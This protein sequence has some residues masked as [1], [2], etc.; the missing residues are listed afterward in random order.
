MRD[1]KVLP[2][3]WHEL[4]ME[5][6][7]E[8][9]RRSFVRLPV[10]WINARLEERDVPIRVTCMPNRTVLRISV[11]RDGT[12]AKR[13]LDRLGKG[14]AAGRIVFGLLPREVV[15]DLSCRYLDHGPDG[16]FFLAVQ[17]FSPRFLGRLASWAL[18]GFAWDV[19][20]KRLTLFLPRLPW[21]GSALGGAAA[22]IVYGAVS[23]VDHAPDALHLAVTAGGG[24]TAF[25]DAYAR[26]VAEPPRF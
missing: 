15:F 3:P 8:L 7:T 13:L 11:S 9:L 2:S 6:D 1:M 10:R 14:K 20:G 22:M 24:L 17:E 21:M 26:E 5:Q 23:R 18:P 4:V 19:A 12:I 16:T 25:F